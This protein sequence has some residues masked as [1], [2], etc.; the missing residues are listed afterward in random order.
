VHARGLELLTGSIL[1]HVEDPWPDRI[2]LGFPFAVAGAFGVLAGVLYAEAPQA[3][4]DR[5]VSRGGIW[6]FRVGAMFY[7]VSLLVQV[8][9]GL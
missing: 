7:V 1:P 2:G 4:R 6:G 9:S 3:H 5:A 8:A